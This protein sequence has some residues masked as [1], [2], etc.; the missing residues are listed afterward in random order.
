MSNP[1]K[2]MP[3]PKIGLRCVRG[4]GAASDG[5][6]AVRILGAGTKPGWGNPG[7]PPELSTSGLDRV[8]EH[9]GGDLTA[10]LEAACRWLPRKAPSRGANQMLALDPPGATATGG[11]VISTS[12]PGPAR[13]LRR[14]ADLVVGITVGALSSPG[15]PPHIAERR[16]G[17]T[18]SRT[19]WR[20]SSGTSQTGSAGAGSSRG[21]WLIC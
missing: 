5:G 7:A 8:V 17:A 13:S 6:A 4:L 3:T 2:V 20:R 19:G 18:L 12:T 9:N 15:E 11:G 1:G 10:L 16:D 14:H 21:A